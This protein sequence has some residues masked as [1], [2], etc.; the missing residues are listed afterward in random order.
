MARETAADLIAQ[1]KKDYG[2]P[3]ER[4]DRA[5]A[6]RLQSGMARTNGNVAAGAPRGRR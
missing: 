4:A 5:A 2:T 3:A 6:A 1:A